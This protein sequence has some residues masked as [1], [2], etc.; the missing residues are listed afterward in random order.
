MNLRALILL[1]A[2]L[3]LQVGQGMGF[4][5][6][7]HRQPLAA[8]PCRLSCCEGLTADRGCCCFEKPAEVPQPAIPSFPP[9]EGRSLLPVICWTAI[10][11][12]DTPPLTKSLSNSRCLHLDAAQASR[13]RP[14]SLAVLHCS[15]LT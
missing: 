15:F 7:K 9:T 3:L 2:A 4:V 6:T 11:F 14:V 1:L 8:E 13:P 12:G 10:V 5:E